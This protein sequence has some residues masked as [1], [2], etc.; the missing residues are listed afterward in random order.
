MTSNG[1]STA[2]STRRGGNHCAQS[3]PGPFPKN[4]SA[5]RHP[6]RQIP[7]RHPQRPIDYAGISTGQSTASANDNEPTERG[8]GGGSLTE[9]GLRKWTVAEVPV[10]S[11]Q[12][13]R[14]HAKGER[15]LF[16]EGRSRKRTVAEIPVLST[17]ITRHASAKTSSPRLAR[18][19]P[20]HENSY[21]AGH[22]STRARGQPGCSLSTRIPTPQGT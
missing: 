7:A 9:G 17:Q 11:T 5:P 15:G 16:T 3:Q 1:Q 2:T 18:L 4:H 19:F 21:T 20:E 22:L 6:A 12:I 10:L 13:T 8:M 14:T